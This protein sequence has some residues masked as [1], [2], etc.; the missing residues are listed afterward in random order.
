MVNRWKRWKNAHLTMKSIFRCRAVDLWCVLMK[1]WLDFFR[2]LFLIAG[3][4]K[5]IHH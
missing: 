3:C 2:Y 4:E 5:M 1:S